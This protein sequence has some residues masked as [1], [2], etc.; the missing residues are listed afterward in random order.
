MQDL[1]AKS[2]TGVEPAQPVTDSLQGAYTCALLPLYIRT[3]W[4]FGCAAS[5]W[6]RHVFWSHI[7]LVFDEKVFGVEGEAS[8]GMLPRQQ[9][10]NDIKAWD[11][12]SI[13]LG[14]GGWGR[15][16]LTPL[17]RGG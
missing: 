3:G 16:K 12:K 13:L 11:V 7:I 1:V 17:Q 2:F 10:R 15:C 14:K 9:H 6:D 5:E 4:S 8:R